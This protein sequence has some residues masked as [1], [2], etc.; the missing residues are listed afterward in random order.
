MNPLIQFKKAIVSAVI[1]VVLG[2]FAFSPAAQ[3]APRPETPDPG[4]VGGAL[5]TADGTNAL[6]N[7]V[8]GAA[9]SAFGW[10]SL[11]SDISG[12]FNTGCGAGTLIFNNGDS[13]TAIGAA[14]LL[15]NTTGNSNTA[16]GAAALVNNT[17]GDGNTAMGFQ[18]LNQNTSGPNT[19]V[20]WRALATN[21]T[22]NENAAV[23]FEALLSNADGNDNVAIGDDAMKNNVSGSDNVAVGLGA[24][25]SVTSN[26]NTLLGSFTGFDL[27]DGGDNIVIGFNVAGHAG[28]S[29]FIRI[30]D[31]DLQA[32]GSDSKVF[33]G[34]IFGATVGAANSNVLI[35]ANGQLGTAVSSARFK[36]DIESMGKS[37]EAI[38]SLRPVTFHYKGD[39]TNMPCFG[40]IAEEVAKVNPDL[41]L[42]D[43]EGKPLSVR[44]EQLN[45]MLLNEFLK[46]HLKVQE[47]EATITQLNKDFRTT[48]TQLTARLDEQAAQIQKVSAQLEASKPAPQV[49]NN[50]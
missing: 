12:S 8:T 17:E 15:N 46:E 30:A 38:F 42:L 39:T 48:V 41:I 22:G 47:Q 11:A 6:H 37:S 32:G 19:A 40:L 43:K 14:T 26:Q 29:G 25:F 27:T 18:T 3:A 23:G 31:N 28:E 10:F 20:G 50:P 5:N 33:I 4:A 13:N 49:V 45:A 2:C 35:N 44:Y 21:T 36:K 34:G 1:A 7:V 9:N 16:V 24:G